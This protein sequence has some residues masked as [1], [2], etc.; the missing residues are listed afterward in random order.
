MKETQQ[1]LA[2]PSLKTNLIYIYTNSG[3]LPIKIE[4]LE[5]QVLPLDTSN[6]IARYINEKLNTVSGKTGKI[7]NEKYKKVLE[8]IKVSK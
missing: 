2:D 5:N 4:K 7:I 6:D 3:Y 8:K 1:L